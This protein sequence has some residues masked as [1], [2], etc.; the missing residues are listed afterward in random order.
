MSNEGLNLIQLGLS[1]ALFSLI[2]FVQ[3]LHYPC[4]VYFSH[5]NF[6]QSMNFHQRR[7]SY[8]VIPLMISELLVSSLLFFHGGLINQLNL[9]IVVTLW[10]STYFMQVPIHHRLLLEN[11]HE[12][13]QRLV[14]TNIFRTALWTI[15]LI[16]TIILNFTML[17]PSGV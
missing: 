5:E 9:L 12:L 2:W 11:S 4:F 1:S 8:L 3:I 13:I 7:I 17:Y 10:V 16:L 6:T 14:K 15:K